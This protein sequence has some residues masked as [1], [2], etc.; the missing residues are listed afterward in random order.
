MQNIPSTIEDEET[1]RRVYDKPASP[2]ALRKC[3]D[4]LDAH[5][6]HFIGLSPFLVIATSDGMASSDVSP[7]GGSAG[8]VIVLDDRHLLLPDLSGNNRLDSFYNILRFPWVGLLFFIPGMPETL[9]VNGRASICTS[10]ELLKHCAGKRLPK[11]GLLVEVNEM[12]LHCSRSVELASLWEPESWPDTAALPSPSRIF[13]DHIRQ[14][15]QAAG[16]AAR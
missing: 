12:F 9:R 15:S 2:G 7:R 6:R 13:S 5:A 10:T 8:H 14:S 3:L 4:H 16:I 11:A 1:L